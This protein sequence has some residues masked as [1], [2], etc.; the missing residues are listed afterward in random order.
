MKPEYVQT[1]VQLALAEDL[2][3]GDITTNHLVASN[4][5]AKARFIAKDEGI[6][7]GVDMARRVFKALSPAVKFKILLKDGQKVKKTDIIAEITGPA[8]ALLSGERVALNLLSFLSG[9]ATQTRRFVDTIKPYR[10]AILDTRKTMPLL[11]QLER[12]AVRTGGGTNHRFNL[13]DMVMIKD[14]HHVVCAQMDIKKVVADLK[15]K[16]KAKIEIEVDNFDQLK[17]AL[18]SKADIILLDNM[19]PQQIAQAV[20]MRNQ[21]KSKILLE[22]SGSIGLHNVRQYAATGVDRIS[23][24][25]LTHS[26]QSLDISM[27]LMAGS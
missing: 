16:T 12:Y 19:K 9:I 3:R 13:N 8:R 7:C 20:K 21:I 5:Q 18:E 2:G 4:I 23:I 22:A 11:R 6:I 14:N 25:A 15:K 10:A 26:Y 17:E 24:G 27:E 1:I